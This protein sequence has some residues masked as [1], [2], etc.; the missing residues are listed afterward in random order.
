MGRRK[1]LPTLGPKAKPKF[2]VGDWVVWVSGP[3]R[4]PALVI[5]DIGPVGHDRVRFYRLR[6]PIWYG[7]PVETEMAELYLEPA[8]QADLDSRWPPD[9]PP[10]DRYP[11]DKT[12]DE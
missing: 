7:K 4:L 5:G 8:T 3:S 2:R 6:Q 10:E 9:E 12:F 1:R 11:I